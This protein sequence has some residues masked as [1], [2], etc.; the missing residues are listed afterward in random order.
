MKEDYKLLMDFWNY[1]N[2]ED[3]EFDEQAIHNY[4]DSLEYKILCGHIKKED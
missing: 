4:F 3:I 1:V 2:D